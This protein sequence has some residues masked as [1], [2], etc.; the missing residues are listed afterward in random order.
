LYDGGLRLGAC[1]ADLIN[2]N[3]KALFKEFE[4]ETKIQLY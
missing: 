4:D 1:G 2:K 3:M